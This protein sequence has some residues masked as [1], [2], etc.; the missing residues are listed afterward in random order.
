[1]YDPNNA[2]NE[3]DRVEMVEREIDEAADVQDMEPV[4]EPTT[5]VDEPC[6]DMSPADVVDMV[7]WYERVEAFLPRMFET[8]AVA[9]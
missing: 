5:G 2:W 1:M 8:A 6:Y 7:S 3:D 4:F 9:A